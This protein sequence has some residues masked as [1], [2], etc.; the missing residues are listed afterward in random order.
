VTDDAGDLE[1]S[2][3]GEKAD[4]SRRLSRAT[5]VHHVHVTNASILSYELCILLK[6]LL[7]TSLI[8]VKQHVGQ[9]SLKW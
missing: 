9:K 7:L 5:A 3:E 6:S 1:V 4:Q 2:C 8:D